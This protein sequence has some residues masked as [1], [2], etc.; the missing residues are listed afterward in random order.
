MS[1]PDNIIV[2]A[3]EQVPYAQ[4]LG[5]KPI[6]IGEE[7]TL[8]MPFSKDNIGNP[9]LPAL[10]GGAIGGFTELAAIVELIHS[11]GGNDLKI[12]PKPIVIN[13]DYLRRG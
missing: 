6:I 9:V 7:L 8:L 12:V 3:L 1:A 5:A 10:H 13:I 2:Q 4:T 11:S